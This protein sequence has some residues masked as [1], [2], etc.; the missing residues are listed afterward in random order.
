MSSWIFVINRP[1]PK[2]YL[3]DVLVI[4][5]KIAS[6]KSNVEHFHDYI[7]EVFFLD[8]ASNPPPLAR[9]LKITSLGSIYNEYNER[10]L[11]FKL[12]NIRTRIN[13][14]LYGYCGTI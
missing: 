1:S 8:S 7:T 10:Q 6:E 3:I 5:K 14:I 4:D 9:E 12:A 11:F 13:L 2:R